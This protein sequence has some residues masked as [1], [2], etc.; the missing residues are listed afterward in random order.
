[1][2]FSQEFL[3]KLKQRQESMWRCPKCFTYTSNSLERCRSCD[4]KRP[5]G[6]TP[7]SSLS[8]AS[9]TNSE[10]EE[11]NTSTDLGDQSAR[12]LKRENTT[13]MDVESKRTPSG[14]FKFVPSGNTQSTSIFDAAFQKPISTFKFGTGPNAVVIRSKSEDIPKENVQEESRKKELDET[15]QVASTEDDDSAT[16]A[17]R[18]RI[19]CKEALSQLSASKDYEVF[20]FGSGECGQ[21]GLGNDC[22]HVSLVWCEA[23]VMSLSRLIKREAD[24][25]SLKA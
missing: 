20:V 9:T 2:S 23:R 7:T 11:T 24:D 13:S 14:G 22:L 17:N 19:S 21:L 8:S 18:K 5:R 15:P 3:E 10:K 16:V 1:M 25:S 4:A 12:T 6:I